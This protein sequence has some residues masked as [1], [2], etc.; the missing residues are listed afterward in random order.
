[1]DN[2]E[3][4]VKLADE[5]RENIRVQKA[6]RWHI[7]RILKDVNAKVKRKGQHAGKIVKPIQLRLDCSR[8][9]IA[10]VGVLVELERISEY[11]GHKYF[12]QEQF[13]IQSLEFFDNDTPHTTTN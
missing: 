10:G 6:I 3:R 2:T 5:L 4:L 7:A 12:T 9:G 13:D 8:N 11:D 1:M